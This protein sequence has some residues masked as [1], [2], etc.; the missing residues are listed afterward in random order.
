MDKEFANWSN[1]FNFE[2]N[3]Y[4][5]TSNTHPKNPETHSPNIQETHHISINPMNARGDLWT[6]L[7]SSSYSF[8]YFLR[9]REH[10]SR[11]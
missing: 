9:P 1:L 8:G 5:Q 10:Q 6:I 2:S 7:C 11:R 4:P 3:S